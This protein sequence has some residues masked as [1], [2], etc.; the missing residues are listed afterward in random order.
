M[1]T[2]RPASPRLDLQRA[3]ASTLGLAVLGAGLLVHHHATDGPSAADVAA[4]PGE[5]ELALNEAFVEPIRYE[6][7]LG[8][9]DDAD[10]ASTLGYL[11]VDGIIYDCSA[12][13]PDSELDAP[14]VACEGPVPELTPEY[15][16]SSRG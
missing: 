16:F 3:L 10:D 13:L 4:A 15:R 6:A 9:S 5:I 8:L 1:S 14:F 7:P 12:Q 11:V 2:H